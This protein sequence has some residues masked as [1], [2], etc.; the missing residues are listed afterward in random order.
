M[1]P[2]DTQVL[3]LWSQDPHERL[4]AAR[5]IAPAQELRLQKDVASGCP[6]DPWPYGMPTVINPVVLVMGPSPGNSPRKGDENARLRK[7][8]VLPTIGK[9]HPDIF[10]D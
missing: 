3:G 6:V 9:P 4:R 5:N 10:Y 1:Q 8:Y 2:A 7:P